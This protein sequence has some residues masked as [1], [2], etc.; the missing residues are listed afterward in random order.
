MSH[1]RQRSLFRPQTLQGFTLVELMVAVTIGLIVL[2]AVAQVFATS[3]GTYL[4]TDGL[5]RAQ[6][7]GRFAMEFVS[8]DIRMAG[9]AGCARLPASQIGNIVDP[10][11]D[12]TTFN[13]D[14]ISGFT[15]I[16]AGNSLG[17]WSPSLPASYF[18]D[19][20]VMAG[21][22]VII[23]QRASS[24]GT[25]LTGNTTPSNANI[26]ILDTAQ[27]ANQIAAGDILMVTD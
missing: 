19:G 26:Q 9:Y 6:E 3:R 1:M 8:T 12:P 17:D 13:P 18:S 14:G 24:L 7:N 5:A 22:D 25:H 4:V 23:I 2:A 16:G 27:L 10:P 21:T 11:A 15:S 20:E